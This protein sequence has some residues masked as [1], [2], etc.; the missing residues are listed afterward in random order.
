[1]TDPESRLVAYRKAV[2]AGIRAALPELKTCDGIGGRFDLEE[3]ESRSITS[4]AVLVGILAAPLKSEAQG[5]GRATLKVAAFVL[6]EGRSR[7]DTSWAI[8]EAIGALAVS[9]S[10]ARWGLDH[11][12]LPSEVRIEPVISRRKRGVALVVVQWSQSLSEIGASVFDEKDVAYTELYIDGALA[13]DLAEDA[14]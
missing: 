4:P 7:D 9:K 8:A 12:A 1:M 2:T 11:L 13:V 3:I 6:T 10:T 14:T 5:T